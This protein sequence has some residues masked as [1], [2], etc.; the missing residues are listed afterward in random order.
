MTQP[1]RSD[2]FSTV[3]PSACVAPSAGTSNSQKER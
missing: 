3:N 2:I 1:H